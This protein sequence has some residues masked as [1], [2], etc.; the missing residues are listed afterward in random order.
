MFKFES[1]KFIQVEATTRCNAWCPGCGRNNGGHELSSKFEIVDLNID[2]FKEILLQLPNLEQ[3]D[4]CGTY[5][6]AIVA[7]NIID[8]ISVA[9]QH[10]KK[11]ILRTNGS[12][13]NIEWWSDFAFLLKDIDHEVWF[14]LDGLADTHSLYRQATDWQ[15][16]INNAKTFIENGGSAVWQFIPFKHNEHQIMDCIRLSQQLKFKRFEFYKDVRLDFTPKNYRTGKVYEIK[17][18]SKNNSMSKYVKEK[19]KV[20]VSDCRHL[21]DPSVYLNANGTISTCCFFNLT[22]SVNQ[23]NE[24]ENIS[25]EL[26]TPHRVCLHHCGS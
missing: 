11:L 19:T 13:R 12:L 23:F 24:L 10:C 6:D 9:K 21:T 22:R 20:D 14:C 26:K 5:G 7:P 18:W 1:V 8:L 2:R 4:F 16:I 3:I 17:P 15:T 25:E